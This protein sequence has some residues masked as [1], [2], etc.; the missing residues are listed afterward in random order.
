MNNG[1][2]Q[3]YQQLLWILPTWFIGSRDA[4]AKIDMISQN[5]KLI[6]SATAPKRCLSDKARVEGV[7]NSHA[8][9]R[10]P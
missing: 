4:S 7:E 9:R 5:A 3:G 1:Y 6:G 2:E 8:V 10:L